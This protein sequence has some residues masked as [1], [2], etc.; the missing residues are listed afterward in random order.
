[1]ACGNGYPGR[2]FRRILCQ[3]HKQIA[4]PFYVLADNDPGGFEFF[5]LVCRGTARSSD[6]GGTRGHPL[7]IPEA[8]YIG[9][10]ASDYDRMA[11]ERWAYINLN[12]RE[13]IQ[14][15]R[16]SSCDWLNPNTPWQ[17]EFRA[18]RLR[19]FKVEME[20]TYALSRSYLAKTYLPAR[21]AAGDHLRFERAV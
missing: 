15:D 16:L 18:M 9:L 4:L 14:L 13:R 3:I 6:F 11:M 8:A 17:D 1:M 12:E 7:A 5:F 19:G 20:A 21:I 2:S 10:R